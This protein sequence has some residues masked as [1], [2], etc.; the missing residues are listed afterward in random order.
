MAKKSPALH[1]SGCG[2]FRHVM[3]MN[4]LDLYDFSDTHIHTTL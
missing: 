3:S 2:I 1:Q 4:G